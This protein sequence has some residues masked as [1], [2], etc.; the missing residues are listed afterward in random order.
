MWRTLLRDRKWDL[1]AL[2][3]LTLVTLYTFAPSIRRVFAADHIYYMAELDGSRSLIDG[4]KHYD[5]SLSRI[6]GKGDEG[7]FRP[8][9]FAW[10]GLN[11]TLFGYHHIGWNIANIL[12][13][14]IAVGS[15]YILLRTIQK[16][17]FAFLFA[18]LFAVMTSQIELVAWCHIGGYIWAA[19]FLIIYLIFFFRLLNDDEH[20]D[21]SLPLQR[22]WNLIGLCV[23]AGFAVFFYEFCVIFCTLGAF[24]W[25][26][27]W[28][29]K[30]GSFSREAFL[31]AVPVALFFM[32]Y[33][34]R[35]LNAP[36]LFLVHSMHGTGGMKGNWEQQLDNVW[37]GLKFSLM[38]A[39]F[40]TTINFTI[41]PYRRFWPIESW[42][43]PYVV[44]NAALLGGFCALLP[45]A[46][47]ASLKKRAA[48]LALLLVSIPCYLGM[49]C[50]GRGANAFING[51]YYSYFFNLL[52]LIIIYQLIDFSSIPKKLKI[53]AGIV[54]I[55][56][57]W[58]NFSYSRHWMIVSQDTS[59]SAHSFL[60]NIA[61]FISKHKNESGFSFR[62]DYDHPDVNPNIPL[63]A[64]YPDK[65]TSI[66]NKSVA[67]IL[68]A[69]YYEKQSPKYILGWND[70]GLTVQ[71][72]AAT[73]NQ[74]P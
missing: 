42:A 74:S 16:S 23:T 66:T 35:S 10:L 43:A 34:F 60:R 54:L 45:L 71:E 20:I 41:A 22:N 56:F 19:V 33:I 48:S 32:I 58:L 49:I 73:P 46:S 9:L 59:N 17:V 40:P 55:C 68:F 18:A 50:L 61:H 1:A 11:N 37:S 5:Y 29:I 65:P 24:I 51:S 28:R 36:N 39:G 8:L 14:V 57:I 53:F 47:W 31:P 21:P 70:R 63:Y 2:I 67:E 7:L 38:R 15:F 64:G 4:L 6:Y 72:M 3:G 25:L 12:I 69:K 27:A 44:L 52:I 26:V 13:H 30:R 62:V